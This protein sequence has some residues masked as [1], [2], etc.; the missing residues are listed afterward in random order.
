LTVFLNI[1][2]SSFSALFHGLS[3]GLNTKTLNCWTSYRI[4]WQTSMH[5]P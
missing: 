2:F 3:S 1:S 4:W 5:E